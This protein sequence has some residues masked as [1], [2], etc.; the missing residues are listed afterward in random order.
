MLRLF[1]PKSIGVIRS[2]FVEYA[3][4]KRRC[5]PASH[6]LSDVTV[7]EDENNRSLTQH[8]SF[9]WVCA[10]PV[11]QYNYLTTPVLLRSVQNVQLL[12]SLNYIALS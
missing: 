4:A 5:L 10:G 1:V 7:F 8:G 12:L 6:E 2:C 9:Q 11:C 3:S